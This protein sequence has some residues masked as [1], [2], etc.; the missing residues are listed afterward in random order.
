MK[1]QFISMSLAAVLAA[2][3]AASVFAV[4]DTPTVFVDDSKI[5]FDDQAPVIL[6]EGTTLVP[7]RGVFES[8]G[9]KVE[10]AE[11]TRTVSVTSKDGNT[12]I[13]L[14]IDDPTM[15]VYDMSGLF[16]ALMSGQDF[17]APETPV[18]LEVAPQIINDRTMI[19]LRAVSEAMD[20]TV[21]WDGDNYT[22]DISTGNAPSADKIESMVSLSLSA[23]KL[24]VDADEEVVIY[25]NAKNLPENIYVSGVTSA[26]E[27]DSENFE[28]VKAELVNGDTIIDGALGAANAEFSKN[29]LKAASITIDAEKAAKEDGSVMKLTFKSLTGNKG[30]FTLSNGYDTKLGYNTYIT[31]DNTENKSSSLY[32]GN[33]LYIDTTAIVVNDDTT[34][35]ATAAPAATASPEATTAPAATTAPEASATPEATATPVATASPE[36]TA[37]PEA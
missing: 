24:A 21:E 30:S 6:G 32:E 37:T 13:K 28:F 9:A 34:P 5:F 23:D 16:G 31:L 33:K 25:V 19:P 36:A 4:N 8:M 29:I 10:W 12:I 15:K 35:E 7:A 17:K 20:A 2:S 11:D 14:V 26:I 18:T 27:Y 1:K 22:I 3:S